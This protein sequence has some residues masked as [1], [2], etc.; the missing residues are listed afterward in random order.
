MKRTL[1]IAGA[2][3]A[4][5]LISLR[6]LNVLKNVNKIFLDGYTGILLRNGSTLKDIIQKDYYILR[7]KDVEDEGGEIIFKA[8][9]DG[10]VALLVPGDALI[11]TTHVNLM[12]EARKR[13][14]NVVIIPGISIVSA[15]IS[16]SGLMIYKLGKIVTLTYPKDGIIYDYP[17]D[18]IKDNSLRNLHT[19][20]LLEMDAER[21]VYMTVHEALKILLEIERI[22][23]EGVISDDRIVVGVSR[24]GSDD[25]RICPGLLK[26]IMKCDL[27]EP[28]H[29][30]ILTSPKLHFIEEEALKVVKDVFCK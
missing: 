23:N 17:Y 25:M 8:L 29:T 19:L 15:A 2:G 18:V 27:G 28:P 21:G 16:L 30:L 4:S 1:Y 24:L 20:L 26:D 7:R 6:A 5:D 11:A 14:Y 10:D 12:I 22:R 13:G 3:L 9:E